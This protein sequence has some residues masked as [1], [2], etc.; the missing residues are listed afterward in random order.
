MEN[1][2]WFVFRKGELL[3]DVAECG[4]YGVPCGEQPPV[5]L[6]GT[7]HVH[8]FDAGNF[9]AKSFVVD[10]TCS[11]PAEM[12]FVPLRRSFFLLT[13][14]DYC[15]AGKMEELVFWDKETQYCGR[16]GGKLEYDSP[17]SKKCVACGHT[18][19]PGLQIAIIVLVKKGEEVLLVQ[20]KGFKADYMGLVAGFVE[21][22]ET[23]EQ[24]VRREIMEET[25][26]KVKELVYVR[27]QA[28]PY[29]CNLMA[30]FVAEYESGELKLQKSE[31]RKGGWFT[32]E[33]MPDLPDEA[34]IAR[35]LVEAWKR[36]EL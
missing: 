2:K 6:D 29:P 25:N 3:L 23:L 28:W 8:V 19:W 11:V 7:K 31:L 12:E 30:G 35:Q 18:V 15:V 26:I 1:T 34:S 21:T 9:I 5:P 22:G 32:R 36:H 33:N 10:E 16:C 13:D 14:G 27:S 17:I 24:A 20:S 4:V